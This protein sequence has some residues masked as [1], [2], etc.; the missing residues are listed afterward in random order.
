MKTMSHDPAA[1]A[2][3]VEELM[4]YFNFR[5]AILE[6]SGSETTIEELSAD[7]LSNNLLISISAI[8][9]DPMNAIF[10]RMA[11]TSC[12]LCKWTLK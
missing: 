4:P 3:S 5:S 9:P 10:E 11:H 8:C 12:K 1:S 7:P 2:L 6:R